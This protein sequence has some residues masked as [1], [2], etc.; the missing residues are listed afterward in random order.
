LC[1]DSMGI[2]TKRRR[3]SSPTDSMNQ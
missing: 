1:N 3:H 2:F